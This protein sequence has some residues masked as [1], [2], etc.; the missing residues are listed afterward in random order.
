MKRALFSAAAAAS[1][2]TLAGI[3][4]A[5]PLTTAFTYQARIRDAGLP[6]NGTYDLRFRVFAAAVGGV[7]QGPTVSFDDVIITNG[8]VTLPLDF[9]DI[10][11]G[12][13]RWLQIEVRPGPSGGLFNILSPRQELTITPH[14]GLTS[15]EV[16]IDDPTSGFLQVR[17]NEDIGGNINMF[18]DDG[19][20]FL[21]LEEDF[22]SPTAGGAFIALR[23]PGIGEAMFLSSND[24]N[25]GGAVIQGVNADGGT[26]FRILGGASSTVARGG[27]GGGLINGGRYE[28]IYPDTGNI[29]GKFTSDAGSSTD[30][31]QQGGAIYMYD[32]NGSSTLT[33]EPRYDADGGYFMGSSATGGAFGSWFLQ[34]NTTGGNSAF[35]MSGGESAF[36]VFTGSTGNASVIMS[37]DAVSSLERLNEPGVANNQAS[38]MAVPETLGSILSRTIDCPTAG[39]VLVL[40]QGDIAITHTNGTISDYVW[41]VSESPTTLPINQ[42]VQ[43]RVPA[44]APSGTYDFPASAHGLFEVSAGLNTF[45]FVAGELFGGSATMFDLQL[46][47]IF[48][49]TAYGAVAPNGPG[50][51]AVAGEGNDML[52]AAPG[53]MTP[54]A[55][56]AEQAQAAD[57]SAWRRQMEFDAMRA[58]MDALRARMEALE[59]EQ[60][61]GRRA[62]G[63]VKPEDTTNEKPVAFDGK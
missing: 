40:A 52:V 47:L 60:A 18:Q 20:L 7:Q 17:I 1:L 45:Y 42:D 19:L 56:A 11:S 33:M 62:P 25:I 12:D 59:A 58:E 23:T 28:V 6:A 51:F 38:V 44:S 24:N 34:S 5:Q 55:I 36:S 54:A 37:T 8:V 43:A 27:G 22:L 29:V 2:M 57:F 14:A 63:K 15:N 16:R 41:G 32:N 13:R 26:T 4:T 10:F 21:T 48:F 39:Y 49:P 31:A 9:G 30:A 53:P 35:T 50:G 46:T 61:A 3:A